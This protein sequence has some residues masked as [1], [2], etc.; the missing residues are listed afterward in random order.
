MRGTIA[1]SQVIP[2][3]VGPLEIVVVLVIALLVFG[4]KRLPQMGRT[5][6]RTMREIRKASEEV[7]GALWLDDR[8]PA[9]T[10]E[11]APAAGHGEAPAHTHGEAPTEA[12]PPPS[13]APEHPDDTAPAAP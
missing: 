10:R 11:E 6:G 8:A 1:P 5:L 2:L 12:A 3:N 4:P 9:P 7:R 13:D